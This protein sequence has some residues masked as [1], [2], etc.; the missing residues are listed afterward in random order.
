MLNEYLWKGHEVVCLPQA[1]SCFYPSLPERQHSKATASAGCVEEAVS[2]QRL[3]ETGG[4]NADVTRAEQASS[5]WRGGGR[6]GGW[7]CPQTLELRGHRGYRAAEMSQGWEGAI[8]GAEAIRPH[9]SS[10]IKKKMYYYS[11]LAMLH[12]LWEL[13]DRS[14][15]PCSGLPDKS[16]CGF[17]I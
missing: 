16:L 4:E 8:Q 11:F 12:G 2:A 10:C 7:R 5:E 9:L 17:F 6:V 1:P 14:C 3:V 13:R 15:V